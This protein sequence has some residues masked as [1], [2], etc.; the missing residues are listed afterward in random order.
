LVSFDACVSRMNLA[1]YELI[2][3]CVVCWITTV[4]GVKVIEPE[5]VSL[6][7]IQCGCVFFTPVRYEGSCICNVDSH[8]TLYL[9]GVRTG[10]PSMCRCSAQEG[11]AA[12]LEM[13]IYLYSELASDAQVRV[14]NM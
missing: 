14:L 7:V 9:V 11:N 3:R 5:V 13:L 8:L 1:D 6:K 4:D 10:F 12:G 2:P